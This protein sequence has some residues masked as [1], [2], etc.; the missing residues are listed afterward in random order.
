MRT[1]YYSALLLLAGTFY[2]FFGGYNPAPA[3]T[4][5]PASTTVIK[6]ISRVG[7]HKAALV[8]PERGCLEDVSTS[9]ELDQ[10]KAEFSFGLFD[11]SANTVQL[12]DDV[13]NP[14]FVIA[15]VPDPLTTHLRLEF[16]RAVEGIEQAA[17]DEEY[18]F[19][20]YWVPWPVEP[21]REF[22]DFESQEHEKEARKQR[23]RFP[24][25]LVF[26]HKSTNNTLVVFL[27]G[28]RPTDGVNREQFCRAKKY[29]EDLTESKENPLYI[30]GTTFSGSLPSLAR[31]LVSAKFE[32]ISGTVTHEPSIE[33][34]E[35]KTCQRLTTL[36]HDTTTAQNAFIPY[37]RENW[38]RPRENCQIAMLSE[39]ETTFGS[40][41]QQRLRSPAQIEFCSQLPT[42][43][44]RAAEVSE[45]T[46]YLRYP[47][48]IAHMRNAYQEYPEL[49]GAAEA[50]ATTRRSLPL[51]LEDK[52]IT[53]DSIPDFALQTPVSQETILTQIAASLRNGHIRFAGIV[54]T[55]VL[56]V[57]FIT[58]FLRS[59]CPEIRLF[60]LSPDL[61]LI[62][63]SDALPFQGMLAITTYP[64]FSGNAPFKEQVTK[65]GEPDEI[66]PDFYQQGFH[67]ALRLLL[68]RA[69]NKKDRELILPGLDRLKTANVKPVLWLTSVGHDTYVP[70]AAIDT[71]W[72]SAKNFPVISSSEPVLEQK[73]IQGPPR[74]WYVIFSLLTFCIAILGLAFWEAS[75]TS[76]S[77]AS[78]FRCDGTS[79]D[80][81]ERSARIAL[82]VLASLSLYFLYCSTAFGLQVLDTYYMANFWIVDIAIALVTIALFF[83]PFNTPVGP[84]RPPQNAAF[85]LS[86]RLFVF[87]VCVFLA[88]PS[89][90]KI[91]TR[92]NGD[93]AGLFFAFRS[94][95]IVSG[96]TPLLPFL[97]IFR[98]ICLVGFCCLT[99]MYLSSGA[100]T[101]TSIRCC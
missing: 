21:N 5:L 33:E 26:E 68:N 79:T 80:R 9:K 88:V 13:Q 76:D 95:R 10:A 91:T 47:R 100:T 38:C 14:T 66:F 63:A 31:S 15:T 55:D 97:F 41:S 43:D 61:L 42:E 84:N 59:A 99:A 82:F 32:A 77:W 4:A 54:G 36:L 51:V 65:S 27:V 62:H 17:S 60:L 92:T 57:L 25:Y 83:L 30:L 22:Q 87:V 96:V 94:S 20:R 85:N 24:G 48:E 2:S 6:K 39:T 49:S 74:L 23:V 46:K 11:R 37:V 40:L 16:D 73:E 67:N 81:R 64:L 98:R 75:N 44:C 28:E 12:R 90:L 45:N 70:I 52:Q 35:D 18:F 69:A 56:D 19:R 71:E 58:R 34:F 50:N 53:G 29:I 78:D 8:T 1:H 93:F 101:I 3:P 86:V 89:I 7:T 72:Q